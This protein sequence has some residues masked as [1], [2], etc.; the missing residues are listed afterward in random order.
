MDLLVNIDVPDIEA[1]I[2]FYERGLGLDLQRRLFDGTVAEMRAATACVYLLEKASGSC[3]HPGEQQVRNYARH[4]T[5]VHLDFVVTDI[6]QALARACH[7]GATLEGTVQTFAWGRLASLS[8]PFGNGFCLV[9]QFQ[10]GY[11]AVVATDGSR[12]SSD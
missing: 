8:D 10:G 7:E 1:A 9:E 11:H 6:E 2:A 5:P 4:W 12:S 3:P